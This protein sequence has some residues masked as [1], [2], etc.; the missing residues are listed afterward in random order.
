MP[1]ITLFLAHAPDADPEK[2]LAVV[3]T[4]MYRLFAVVARDQA[5]GLE[6]CKRMVAEEG[7]HSIVLC[8][9]H[10]NE[11]VGAIAQAVGKDVGV[12]VARGDAASGRIAAKAME[13]AGWFAPPRQ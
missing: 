1:F 13:E 2:H 7:V 6:V 5:Q 4:G 3:D 8:P 11:D 9:G 12:T 10:S